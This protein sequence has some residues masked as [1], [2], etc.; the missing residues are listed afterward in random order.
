V[1]TIDVECGKGTYIRTLAADLGEALGCG[2][3]LA[4]LCRT[5][6]GPFDIAGAATLDALEREDE[7]ARDA[8]LLPVD[9]PLADLP[10]LD[11][12]RPVAHLLACGQ[13]PRIAAAPGRYRVYAI[14]G[15]F[16]G[17]ADVETERLI[18][19]RLVAQ[20]GDGDAPDG[21]GA[22][23]AGAAERLEC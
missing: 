14:G 15:H 12:E 4:A 16:V 5:R 11:V 6:T 9:A 3:H 19:L 1:A 2:A 22:R 18:A 21:A 23:A 13:R 8:R 20:R 10:R 17:V 7:T